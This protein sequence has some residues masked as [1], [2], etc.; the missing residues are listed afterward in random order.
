MSNRLEESV[1]GRRVMFVGWSDGCGQ[2]GC[3]V[4][5]RVVLLHTDVCN[6]VRVFIGNL[7]DEVSPEHQGNSA[8]VV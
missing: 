5:C 6:G 7:F 4:L 1:A 3:Q 8:S 2:S